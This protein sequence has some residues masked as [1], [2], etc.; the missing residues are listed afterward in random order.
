M[1]P[2]KNGAPVDTTAAPTKRSFA[3]SLLSKEAII[4]RFTLYSS[5]SSAQLRC[6]RTTVGGSLVTAM[7]TNFALPTFWS[8]MPPATASASRIAS[9][10]IAALSC[11]P[12]VTTTSYPGGAEGDVATLGG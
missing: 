10:L 5:A 9:M 7:V 11:T 1:R 12:R 2:K 4:S 8:L 3:S 6:T